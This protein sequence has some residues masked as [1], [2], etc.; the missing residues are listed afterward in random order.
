M[1]LMRKNFTALRFSNMSD[2]LKSQLNLHFTQY[3]GQYSVYIC[4]CVFH[5]DSALRKLRVFAYKL[6]AYPAITITFYFSL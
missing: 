5:K 6:V 2:I 4:V 1:Y 3:L